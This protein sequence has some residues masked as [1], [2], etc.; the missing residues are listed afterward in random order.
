MYPILKM[1]VFPAHVIMAQAQGQVAPKHPSVSGIGWDDLS[2][3][4]ISFIALLIPLIAVFLRYLVKRSFKSNE[5]LY[6][7]LEKISDKIEK[8]K[9]E[10]TCDL[11]AICLERQDHCN[12]F[13]LSKI[14]ENNKDIERLQN[15][16][17]YTN[18]LAHELKTTLKI[19]EII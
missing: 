4:L 12:H 14:S 3:I 15:M 1:V 19:K 9:P 18:K 16:L 7:K 10:I 5:D 17:E 6:T 8:L 11:K 2:Q 13:V